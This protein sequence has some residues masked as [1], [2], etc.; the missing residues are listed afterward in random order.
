MSTHIIYDVQIVRMPL[1]TGE[2]SQD[3]YGLFV[4]SGA[5][6]S[7]NGWGKNSARTRSWGMIY[8]GSKE[9]L[10]AY[11]IDWSAY[12][13][14]GNTV[15][16]SMG[17]SGRLKPQQWIRKLRTA[18]DGAAAIDVHVMNDISIWAGQFVL[19]GKGEFDGLSIN[20]VIECVKSYTAEHP[21]STTWQFLRVTGPATR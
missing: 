9:E 8:G 7:Y 18:L 21:G 3:F 15:W 10:L 14:G 17:R 20:K 16:R 5:S 1:Q 13:R 19:S 12:F 4:S 2:A 11:A 6:N